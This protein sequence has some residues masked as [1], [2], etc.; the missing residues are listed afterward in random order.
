VAGHARA[1]F[2]RLLPRGRPRGRPVAVGLHQGPQGLRIR[3]AAGEAGEAAAEY[4]HPEP[5]PEARFA[6]PLEALADC[7]GHGGDAATLRPV[8]DGRV[9]VSWRQAGAA[10]TRTYPTAGLGVPDFPD[11][12]DADAS[13]G[14]ELLSAL[15]RAAEVAAREG[16]R[17]ALHRVQLGGRRGEVASTDGRQLLI[18]G[19]FHFPWT[20]DLLVPRVPLFGSPELAAGGP[21]S[22]ALSAG[23]ALFRT[24]G[25]AVALKVAEG[26]RFPEVHAV[27]P[28]PR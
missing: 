9:E 20:Q 6:V 14:P 2:Q 19:G 26:E 8:G 23:H 11:W 25:W 7:A 28:S 27:V 17:F 22:V 1:V 12:P 5:G 4:H 10:P 24:G 13:N 16:M 18:D 3:C 21:V 15:G